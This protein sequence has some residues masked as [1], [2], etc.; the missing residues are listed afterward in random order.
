MRCGDRDR[1]GWRGDAAWSAN[2]MQEAFC[3]FE[4]EVPLIMGSLPG[5]HLPH[6]L[7][8]SSETQIKF[9]SHPLL[10]TPSSKP[11]SRKHNHLQRFNYGL[12]QKQLPPPTVM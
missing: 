10:L 4:R 9:L 2:M 1:M 8:R 3:I 11:V 6:N 12:E 5:V 7:L